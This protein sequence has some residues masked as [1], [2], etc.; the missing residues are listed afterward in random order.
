MRCM[1]YA[2]VRDIPASWEQ[3]QGIARSIERVPAGLLLCVAGPTDEGI[4][5]IE[6]W[7]SEVAW[8]QFAPVL[9]GALLSVDPDVGSRTIVRDLRGAHLVIGAALRGSA[10]HD[11]IVG[12]EPV[13]SSPPLEKERR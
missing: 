7:D 3:Y 10:T 8:R 13:R 5:I 12:H 1:S 2:L 11:S 9:A 4:R 6:I